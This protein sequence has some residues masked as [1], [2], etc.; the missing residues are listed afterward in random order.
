MPDARP[1]GRAGVLALVV[2]AWA[3]ALAAA[4]VLPGPYRPLVVAPVLLLAPGFAAWRAIAPGR[5]VVP[6]RDAVASIVL[7]LAVHAGALAA[8][9]ALRRSI[10][11]TLGL[12]VAASLVLAAVAARAGP[13]PAPDRGAPEPGWRFFG[14]AAA[15]SGLVGLAVQRTTLIEVDAP[16]HLGRVRK[17]AD[18]GRLSPGR[19]TELVDGTNHPG[20]AFPLWHELIA[21]TA[22][23]A[24]IDPA[25]AYVRVGAPFAM[26]AGIA[27]YAL[28]AELVRRRDVALTATAILAGIAV[29]TDFG[30][31]A[32]WIQKASWS[33][34]SDPP[35]AV[36]Q[37]L[38][39]TLVVA[40]LLYAA[41]P[42][43]DTLLLVAAGSGAV[44]IVHPTYLPLALIPITGAVVL[45]A[46][47]ERR[48]AWR[49]LAL[50]AAALLAPFAAYTAWV[51]PLA[52]DT[53]GRTGSAQ[54][55]ADALQLYSGQLGQVHEW[56]GLVLLDP[57]FLLLKSHVALAAMAAAVAV[58]LLPARRARWLL[59]AVAAIV[60]VAL[61]PP[62]FDLL[63]RALTISQ[64]RRIGL[65]LPAAPV[66]AIAALALTERLRRPLLLLPA[67][68]AVG[69][70]AALIPGNSVAVV[71]VMVAATLL[72]VA[73]VAL[74]ALRQ[75]LRRAGASDGSGRAP[76]AVVALCLAGPAIVAGG[77]AFVDH[78]RHPGAPALTLSP[79]LLRR[80]RALP[81]GTVVAGDLPAS[82][83]VP[84]YTLDAIVAAP[85]KN[86]ADTSG[87]DPYRR[88]A[89]ML[90]VLRAL[91]PD[92]TRRAI[93]RRY[94]AQYLLLDRRHERPVDQVLRRTPGYRAVY[95]ELQPP[96]R[97]A[98]YF[99]LYRLGF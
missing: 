6:H 17:L 10:V 40:V 23:A 86:V 14:A 7:G 60:V 84:A 61:V 13:A 38:L 20:Y 16:F 52:R 22:R 70:A 63:Q 8:T 56:H 27:T 58:A 59:G 35:S 78:V 51:L 97:N 11:L 53:A 96:D 81:R 98:S 55:Q 34:L 87:N 21:G 39:P 71:A 45:D 88:A 15:L 90:T 91:T 41:E 67:A 89:D 64:A 25:V 95:R 75:P 29:A 1:P 48:I 31:K 43:P 33:L 62:L 93:L 82:Y 68:L 28:V 79:E 72:L 44:S 32:P 92:A 73:A 30:Q 26:L 77:P 4:L 80:L 37:I 36:T 49:R 94:H 24:R 76:A 42:G 54:A 3:A 65:F 74:I 5:P 69:I 85:P 18:L 50:G 66:L 2:A 9:F 12:E 46:L 47:H 99:V 57:R 83:L 19:M